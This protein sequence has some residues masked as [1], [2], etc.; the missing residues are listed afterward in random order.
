VK[1]FSNIAFES[2]S[3]PGF[4]E[5]R[6]KR[7]VEILAGVV[8]IAINRVKH[9]GFGICNRRLP[10]SVAIE[11]NGTKI[12]QLEQSHRTGGMAFGH[13]TGLEGV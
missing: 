6:Q 11:K 10:S 3:S 9:S 13:L 1:G 12:P 8:S 2:M 5:S 4:G 7:L